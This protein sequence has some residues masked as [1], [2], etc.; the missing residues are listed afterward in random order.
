[1]IIDRRTFFDGYRKAFGPLKQSQV[2]GL[3]LKLG[4]IESDPLPDLRWIAYY[5]ATVKHECADTWMPIDERGGDDYFNRR[6]GPGTK[7]GAVLGN[8]QPGDGA[9][10]H[11]RGDIQCTGRRNYTLFAGLLKIDLVGNPDLAKVP[12]HAYQIACIGMANGLF[13]GKKLGDYL[14]ATGIDWVNARRVVNGTDKAELIAGY[15]R[16]FYV[17]LRDATAAAD[18]RVGPVDTQSPT[19]YELLVSAVRKAVADL[20]AAMDRGKSA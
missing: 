8:T 14:G 15:A 16:S 2:V 11:G 3:E 1:M 9:L 4:F 7:V 6:Y 12:L 10:F 18:E 20:Q 19:Q 5:L 17:V 13:T